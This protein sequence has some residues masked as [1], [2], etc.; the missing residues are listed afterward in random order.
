M[1]ERTIRDPT[2][3]EWRVQCEPVRVNRYAP[4]DDARP[5]EPTSGYRYTF[6]STDGVVRR[7]GSA[8][9]RDELSDREV[10]VLLTESA[11]VLPE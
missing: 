3:T 8:R 11:L 10:Y 6:T 5:H 4:R 9:A 2:G 1:T 7:A